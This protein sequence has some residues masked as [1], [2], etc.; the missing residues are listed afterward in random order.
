LKTYEASIDFPKEDLPSVIWDKVGDTYKMKPNAKQKIYAVLGSIPT[1]ETVKCKAIH[2][3][4]SLGT[5]QYTDEADVDIHIQPADRFLKYKTEE[6]QKRVMKWVNENR[7]AIDGYI[8]SHPIE[9][10]IQLIP[11]QD[12]VG[13]ACYDIINDEWL[14]GPKL[15]NLDYNPYEDFS[16]ILPE[17]E[18]I[19]TSMDIKLGKLKR[20]VID[21]KTIENAIMN[22][23]K[24]Q[25]DK[26]KKAL[27]EK[28][29]ELEKD[30]MKLYKLRKGYID[31]R[32]KASR[33]AT[34]EE[35]L[36]D[37][38]LAKRW[39]D[40]NAAHKFFHRYKYTKLVGDL[41]KLI[42]DDGK[43]SDDEITLMKGML[44]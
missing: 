11:E 13:D 14:K 24:E 29:D 16:D 33:P 39:R 40:T 43:L 32:H 30:V 15:V 44:T 21:F 3:V 36:E 41:A 26:L 20:G 38:K 9:V 35:A 10:Y 18:E 27:E 1:E 34:E 5:N 19:A 8:G 2:L 37:V 22:L 28:R 31:A 6:E 7:D 42:K 4:G 23:P 12:L 17:V 25:R